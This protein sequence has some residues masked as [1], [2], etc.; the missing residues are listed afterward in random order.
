MVS[1]IFFKILDEFINNIKNLYDN[2]IYINKNKILITEDVY[3]INH[4]INGNLL[5]K[6]IY[7]QANYG[8]IIT[9]HNTFKQDVIEIRHEKY[10]L[11]YNLYSYL[12][13]GFKDNLNF[14]INKKGRFLKVN[15]SLRNLLLLLGLNTK[16]H[17]ITTSNIK[18]NIYDILKIEIII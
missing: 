18:E 10:I 11:Y 17:I 15:Y 5:Q 12:Y 16:Y 3:V 13:L 4:D 1:L 2:K 8:R 14:I 9:N 6:F 7:I